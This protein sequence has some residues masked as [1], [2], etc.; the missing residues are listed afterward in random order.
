[1]LKLLPLYSHSDQQ[2]RRKGEGSTSPSFLEVN[3]NICCERNNLA[4]ELENKDGRRGYL[5]QVDWQ[6][7]PADSFSAG[8]GRVRSSYH[9]KN[10]REEYSRYSEQL[11]R[12]RECDEEV[13][14]HDTRLCLC[15]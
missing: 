6:F 4:A 14:K 7:L 11:Q 8:I 10:K 12:S 3:C 15:G 1:M 5:D 2:G 9:I 13:K